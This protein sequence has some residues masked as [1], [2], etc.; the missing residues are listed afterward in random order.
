MVDICS[1]TDPLYGKLLVAIYLAIIRDALD[2][3]PL[4]DP[5]LT[6]TN[7]HST[8]TDSRKRRRDREEAVPLRRSR[9]KLGDPSK[10]VEP[11]VGFLLPVLWTRR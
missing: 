4:L 7:K 10:E 1:H 6:E 3:A 8:Q 5:S 2:R 9:R 11:E